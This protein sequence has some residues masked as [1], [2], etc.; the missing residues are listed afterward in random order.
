MEY[1]E[2]CQ[3]TSHISAKAAIGGSSNSW[4]LWQ[5]SGSSPGEIRKIPISNSTVFSG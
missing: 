1:S 2:T 5:M 3:T 4:Q